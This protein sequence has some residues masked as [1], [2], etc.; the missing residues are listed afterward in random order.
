M[1]GEGSVFKRASD[2]YWAAQLSMGPR[3][4]RRTFTAYRRT[5][6]EALEAL[7]EL[8]KRAGRVDRTTITVG[9]F[10]ERWVRDARDIRPTT[11]HGYEAAIVT[12]LT[13]SLG[14]LRLVDLTPLDVE[15]MLARLAPTMRPKTLRNV[16]VVLRRALGQAVRAELVE[17]N[18]ADK[19]Y[20]DPPKVTV[21]EPDALTTAQIDAIL[22]ILPGNPPETPAHPLQA[23][24]LVALGTG[25]RQGEQLGLAWEDLDLDGGTLSVRKELARIDG[26]YE[27]VEPKTP[28]SRRS[29]PLAPAIVAALKAHRERLKAAGFVPTSTGPVFIN[30]VGKPLSGSVLT[31]RWYDLLELAKIDRRPWKIL[32]ATFASQLF[33]A[34]VPDRTVADLLGHSRT[35]T[36]QRHYIASAGA[37]D[38][39]AAI[40]RFASHTVTGTVTEERTDVAQGGQS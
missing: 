37:G 31:H 32:R 33:A 1:P 38:A 39:L 28:R 19:Q 6:T 10:L 23:H 34:G 16:H 40:E 17:R 20:V 22:A 18:V 15:A 14:H 9:A 3:G 4:A 2:G 11:R 21:D 36:T 27:R 26:K 7:A 35:A 12:H 8:R 25:L 29:V 13:P 30:S 5:R 24:V